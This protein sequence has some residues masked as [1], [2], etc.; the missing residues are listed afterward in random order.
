MP[1][2]IFDA[3]VVGAG[4][5]GAAAAA[6]LQEAGHR[7]VVLEARD[8]AGGRAFTRSFVDSADL[9]EFGGSWIAPYQHRV[10][11]YANKCGF[12]LRPTAPVT[13][14]RWHDGSALRRDA[15][16]PE[17]NMADYE[18]GR[19]RIVHDAHRYAKGLTTDRSGLDLVQISFAAYLNRINVSRALK[20]QAMAWWCISGN[21]DPNLISAAE[22]IASCAHGD[23]SPEGMMSS[24]KHTLVSGAGDLV[25][26]MIDASGATL[27]LKS[28]VH[29]IQQFR[30]DVSAVCTNGESYRARAAVIAVPLNVLKAIRFAPSL[31]RRKNDAMASGHG[32]R[33]FKIWIK[34]RGVQMGVLATGGLHGL[35]WAFAEREAAD[36]NMMIVGF[37]LLDGKFD[38]S[39]RADVEQGLGRFFPEATLVAWD[40]HDWVN[41]PYS[42]GTWLALPAAAPWI[43]DHE[44]WRSEGKV[45]FASSDFAPE[46]P[47]WFE[48]AIRSGE[49]AARGIIGVSTE[50][51]IHL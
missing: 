3:V 45:F 4:F 15:P 11:H 24:L 31:Q 20:S 49:A 28:E 38:P 16:A 19:K 5:A 8:R 18:L 6:V 34:A 12:L 46:T 35:Q 21:G 39:A 27:H 36:G 7:T 13:A 10:R 1:E 25:R 37:G 47:G 40:W 51:P 22:F 30:S 43:A 44:E 9:L 50:G 17:A 2:H 14:R 26:R 23:G 41:D 48:S 29:S 32:G 42:R 33:S